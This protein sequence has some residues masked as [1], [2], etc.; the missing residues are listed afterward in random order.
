M[1][2]LN[3]NRTFPG[4]PLGTITQQIAA[5][6]NDVIYPLADAFI[7]LHS[8]GSSLDINPSAIVDPAKDAAL[9]RRNITAVRA[10]GAPLTVVI[11]NLGGPRTSTASAVRAGLVTVGTEMAG[12]RHGIARSAYDLP[13]RR[14]Q[15]SQPS[16]RLAAGGSTGYRRPLT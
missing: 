11:N 14:P 9:H 13:A 7:D 8:G 6:V 15:R 3:F 12:G 10:F 4:D 2:G 5:Y 16:R 1:D